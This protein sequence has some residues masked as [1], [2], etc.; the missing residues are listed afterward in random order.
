M[1]KLA[2][3]VLLAALVVPAM[4][5]ETITLLDYSQGWG[6][7]QR[8][9]GQVDID[10]AQPRNG[11]A[12]V[13]M[14]TGSS[15][16]KAMLIYWTGSALGTFNDLLNGSVS[17]DYYRDGS[18]SVAAH[19]A[20]AFEFIVFKGTEQYN[21]KWEAAYNGY[22]AANPVLVDQWVNTGDITEG[23]WWVWKNGDLGKYQSLSAWS[24]QL[25]GSDSII[26][27]FNLSLGSGWTGT[28]LGYVDTVQI[29]LGD[30]N[31]QYNFESPAVVPAPGAIL[32]GMMGTGLVGWLRRRR[33]L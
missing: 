3:L 22:S 32:L 26:A 21:L 2:F 18:S 31:K 8:N 27:S 12:S 13:M 24:N 25:F 29:Q 15:S 19:F 9:N 17:F 6:I 14:S 5:A 16:D 4:A 7:N 10:A 28:Y 11:N 33:S 23:N 1:K 30:Y 20:P